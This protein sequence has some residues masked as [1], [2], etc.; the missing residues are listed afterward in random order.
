MGAP[1]RETKQEKKERLRKEKE[2]KAKQERR[3]KKPVHRF[4][5]KEPSW[6][7]LPNHVCKGY[8]FWILTLDG[9]TFLQK[10]KCLLD[11]ISKMK[12]PVQSVWGFDTRPTIAM[13]TDY[14]EK[15]QIVMSLLH[16]N[17][18]LR[19]KFKTF[20]TNA[21]IK[22]FQQVNAVDP[23]T[24][25]SFKQPI[26]FHSFAQTKTYTFE[27]ESF[28]KHVHRKLTNNDGH[29]SL[30]V[31]PRNPFTNEEFSL[32]Q[33]MGLL[34]QCKQAGHTTWAVEAFINVCYDITTFAAV[35]TK[36]L[37]LSALR[38]TMAD[39]K[40]WDAIDTLYDFIKSEHQYHK[41]IFPKQIYIWSLHHAVQEA[42]MQTWKKMCLKYYE[43]DILVDD[44][45]T[46]ELLFTHIS[47]KTFALC[48]T[49]KELQC[50]RKRTLKSLQ[51]SDGSSSS[52]DSESEG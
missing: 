49:P 52:G 13:H 34:R 39:S 50:L 6:L 8:E 26:Q 2:W 16:Q 23:I 9:K 29:I 1:R 11:Q 3:K 10:R 43:T 42:R 37:R 36:P 27:A 51:P 20:F 18:E 7:I 28:V 25:E 40:S 12:Q 35:H 38:A 5:C 44:A 31:N 32:C 45:V 30:P 14:L 33:L 17:Q 41:K 19:W 22:R 4:F 24:M 21:R 15:A 48:S 47:T 46:K